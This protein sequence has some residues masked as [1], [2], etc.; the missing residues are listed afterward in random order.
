MTKL[1]VLL[2]NFMKSYESSEGEKLKN[3]GGFRRR[4]VFSDYRLW[5]FGQY[6]FKDFK[7]LVPIEFRG[8]DQTHYKRVIA[9]SGSFPAA[10]T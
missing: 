3:S 4:I 2:K 1:T 8:L 5:V 6:T 10:V 9:C 7:F